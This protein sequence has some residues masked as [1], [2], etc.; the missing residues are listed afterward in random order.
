MSRKTGLIHAVFFWV[1]EGGSHSDAVAIAA[2]CKKHLTKISTVVR[3]EVGFPAGTARDVV[4]ASYGVGLHVEFED[5]AGHDVYQDHPDHLA[6]IE[7]CHQHWSK[8]VVYDTAIE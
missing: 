2:G 6:F 8:V 5:M 4:D 7:E 3:I 1:R